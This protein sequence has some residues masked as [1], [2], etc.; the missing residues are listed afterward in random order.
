M[1]F[2]KASRFADQHDVVLVGYRGV[3]GSVKLDCPEVESAMR[4]SADYLG[5]TSMRAYASAFSA[6]AKRLQADGVDLAGYTLAQR[7][8][9]FERL[10]RP[11]AIPAS[12]CSARAP[13]RARR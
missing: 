7:V 1:Q 9:D 13:A 5:A 10:D 3:D 4:H 8:D 12:T 2:E 11:L 6:C